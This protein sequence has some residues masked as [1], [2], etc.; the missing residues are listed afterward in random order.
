[1]S[2]IKST[3]LIVATMA[4]LS[5]ATLAQFQVDSK[6][7]CIKESE[8]APL[9]CGATIKESSSFGIESKYEMWHKVGD[10][11]TNYHI[12]VEQDLPG[13]VGNMSFA[14]DDSGKSYIWIFSAAAAM[15]IRT[16]TDV[17]GDVHQT[18]YHVV[19]N[20]GL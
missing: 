2:I 15:A 10:I 17:S 5:Q 13:G 7:E 6:T 4:A 19:N 20:Q 3:A 18:R 9:V 14:T 11:V 8:T 12:S 16:W 1:M